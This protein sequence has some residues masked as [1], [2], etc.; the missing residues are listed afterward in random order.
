MRFMRFCDACVNS[1]YQALLFPPPRE[2][3][4]FPTQ[5][6]EGLGKRLGYFVLMGPSMN[7]D[8]I[9]ALGR[10]QDCTKVSVYA[11]DHTFSAV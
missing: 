2:A 1:V 9:C 4:A 11:K 7:S 5:E 3:H 10:I 8:Q 6:K